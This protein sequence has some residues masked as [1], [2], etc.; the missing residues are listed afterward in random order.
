LIERRTLIA[1]LAAPLVRA[2][3]RDRYID[4]LGGMAAA[5]ASAEPAEFMRHIDESA[6]DRERL[7][8]LV[9][10]LVAQ[11]EVTS[12]VEVIEISAGAARVDW[13]M[14]V[15]ARAAGAPVERRRRELT[16]KLNPRG[17][18]LELRPIDFFAP[19]SARG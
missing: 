1:A 13:Y 8:S 15:R 12:S 19:P 4:V 14:E 9:A 6:A 18:V 7:R 11:A 5:L 17:R 2:Q 16:V 3:D 10:A